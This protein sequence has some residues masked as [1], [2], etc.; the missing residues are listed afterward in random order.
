[1]QFHPLYCCMYVSP[2]HQLLRAPYVALSTPKDKASTASPSSSARASPP[3]AVYAL[4]QGAA[5]KPLCS[6]RAPLK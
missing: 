5:G 2:L 1:M 6:E 3:S 4:E